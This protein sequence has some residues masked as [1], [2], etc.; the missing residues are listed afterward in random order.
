[1]RTTMRDRWTTPVIG[2]LTGLLLL[3]ASALGG[4]PA[5]G[6]R[7]LVVTAVFSAILLAFGGRSDT[8]GVLAGRP[9]DE[10][11]ARIG[12]H[13]TAAAGVAAMLVALGGLLWDTAH[14]QAGTEFALVLG[15]GGAVYLA[16]VAWFRWR[17]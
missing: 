15:A 3:V 7:M 1:M 6:V 11:Y 16:S 5:V 2:V 14:G 13:A 8:V 17:S 4:E 9:V 10:R 12:V